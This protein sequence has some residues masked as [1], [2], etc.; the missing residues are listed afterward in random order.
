MMKKYTIFL[1]VFVLVAT[2]ILP[3]CN[4]ENVLYVYNWGDYIDKDVL[5][6]FEQ[7]YG[8]KVKYQTFTTNEDMYVKI[9]SGSAKYDVIFPSDYM[10]HRMAQE[11]LLQPLNMNNIP[12]FSLIDDVLKGAEYDP[13]NTYSVPYMW[14][15]IGILYNKNMVKEPV[16]SWNILWDKKY[17][18]QILMVDSQRDSIGVAL[19]RLGYSMNSTNKKEVDEAKASLIEQ[20]PLVLAYVVDEARD[21]MI[22]NEAALAVVWSGEAM[23]AMAENKDLAYAYPKEGT[24]IWYDCM[25][26]PATSKNKELA[27]KF[28]NFMCRTDIA[29]LNAEY[30]GY[31]APQKEV[32]ALLDEEIQNNPAAYPGED[33]I[34]DCEVFRYI[35][36]FVEYY[37][38]AWI[39]IT[40]N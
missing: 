11:G 5:K 24:N 38:K 13:D 10:L 7:E 3:G 14:G 12:N 17:E 4:D 29:L 25:A 19:K 35:G 18:K 6:M 15:T 36:E 9:N 26:I 31:S 22:N 40:A 32:V 8:I 30:T 2:M 33:I 28:I 27:E 20:K 16:D 23:L 1:L 34:K 37:N 21:K 39:E